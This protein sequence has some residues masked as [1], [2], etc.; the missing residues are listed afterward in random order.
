MLV[1]DN[2]YKYKTERVLK[3]GSLE[4]YYK[5]KVDDVRLDKILL[6]IMIVYKYLRSRMDSTDI[7]FKLLSEEFT[8]E[9]VRI[10]YEHSMIPVRKSVMSIP[11]VR[12]ILGTR[13]ALVMP[14]I[15]LTSRK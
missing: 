8:L 1:G 4:Y 14:G 15:V 13:E 3:A 5:I 9:D 7:C 12:T 2:I 6:E 11:A 10:V